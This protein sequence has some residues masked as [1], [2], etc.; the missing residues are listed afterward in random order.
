ML[1]VERVT[2]DARGWQVEARWLVAG[3]LL[4]ILYWIFICFLRILA[5]SST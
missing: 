4:V 2:L 5:I 1:L 3:L